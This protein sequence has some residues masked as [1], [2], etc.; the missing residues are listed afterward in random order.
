MGE[1]ER[2]A[3]LLAAAEKA[4]DA[5]VTALQ[6]V[7]NAAPPNQWANGVRYVLGEAIDAARTAGKGPER[8]RRDLAE[9]DRPKGPDVSICYPSR[10]GKVSTSKQEL[11][12]IT[13]GAL[14]MRGGD[15]YSRKTGEKIGAAY[16]PW[17]A[18]RPYITEEERARVL[19]LGWRPAPAKGAK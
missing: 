5:L 18:G 9:Y 17:G 15:R 3:P 1:S 16:D 19:A 14:V 13:N 4:S 10:G 7:L 6:D 2:M 8:V 12:S 11:G